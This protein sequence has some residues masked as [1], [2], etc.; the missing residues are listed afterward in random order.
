MHGDKNLSLRSRT[1]TAGA[2][3]RFYV[4][5]QGLGKDLVLSGTEH[6]H[7]ANVLRLKIGEEVVIVCGDEFDYL[8]KIVSITKSQT[9]LSIAKKWRNAYNPQKAVTV[10]MGAIKHD[11]LAL[12]VEKLN[13]IGVAEVV[14]FKSAHCQNVPV[15]IDK[16]QA[17]ANQSCKQCG[18]SIPLKVS[19]II[20]FDKLPKG[21]L[22][23]DEKTTSGKIQ[24]ADAII[25]GPEGGFTDSEREHLRKTSTPISLGPRILRA[26][27]AAIV[28]AA[29][30]M[31]KMGEL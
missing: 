24:S 27:T 5:Q 6:N 1:L 16:L 15:K 8:Y 14:L 11:N 10:Y 17:V 13:E 21:T 22:F 20:G 7:L 31:S 26:E 18:R 9:A 29:L 28:G 25:I 23:A 2:V 19:G 30:L 4:N 3:R 12:A